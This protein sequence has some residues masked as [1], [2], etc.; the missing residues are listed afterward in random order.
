MTTNSIIEASLKKRQPKQWRQPQKWR[1][2]YIWWQPQKW[3]RPQNYNN[4]KNKDSLK[5]ED[6][7]LKTVALV[8]TIIVILDSAVSA[9]K[10]VEFPQDGNDT[11]KNI[12]P[13]YIL[14]F[15]WCVLESISPSSTNSYLRSPPCV[16]SAVARFPVMHHIPT[17]SDISISVGWVMGRLCL[18]SS[19]SQKK[20]V[21]MDPF[22]WSPSTGE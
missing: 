9:L 2:S 10:C 4:L 18:N 21:K 16:R 14:K 5:N 22:E 11:V 17:H 20:T 8:Y 6:V 19:K 15:W 13:K 1:R 3:R 12:P 7:I